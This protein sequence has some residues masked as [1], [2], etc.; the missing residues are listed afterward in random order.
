MALWRRKL[1]RPVRVLLIGVTGSYALGLALFLVLRI[2]FG[3]RFW[4]LSLLNSFALLGFLP[5]FILLPLALLSK[6][7][8]IFILNVALALIG[9]LWFGPYYLPK[10]HAA[11][12]GLA[13]RIVTFNSIR[14]V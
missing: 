9:V 11:P 4:W 12:S 13:L 7:R 2:L 1:F 6:A 5:L 8:P 10:A 3:D 14:Q